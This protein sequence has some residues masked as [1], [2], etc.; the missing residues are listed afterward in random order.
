MKKYCKITPEGTRDL[1]FEECLTYRNIEKLLAGVFQSRGFHEAKKAGLR[2]GDRV[3]R[4]DD[5]LT[6]TNDVWL[7]I[8]W[9]AWPRVPAL[10]WTMWMSCTT[11]W[12]PTAVICK[13]RLCHLRRYA[14]GGPLRC[15]AAEDEF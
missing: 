14:E 11:F 10:C 8:R 12:I 13:P 3:V 4:M 7:R 2:L 5:T 1:L 9:T 6:E 15:C